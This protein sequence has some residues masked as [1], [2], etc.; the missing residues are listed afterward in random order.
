MLAHQ[1]VI[2]VVVL[3]GVVRGGPLPIVN[4]ANYTWYCDG[5]CDSLTAPNIPPKFGLVLMG[6]GTDV[7]AA[8][9]WMTEKCGGGDF[10]VLRTSGDG[11]YNRYI[12]QLSEQTSNP[13]NSVST[14]VLK[15]RAA[16]FDSFVIDMTKNASGLWFA[17][18]DQWTYYSFWKGSPLHDAFMKSNYETRPIGG[19]SAGN[20][21]QPEFVYTAE[22]DSAYSTETL[23]NPYNEFVQI[24]TGLI[25][26]QHLQNMIT[27][28]H[29]AERDR[30]GRLVGF[31]SRL[32]AD[33]WA[34]MPPST[35]PTFG[36]CVDPAY[37]A[38]GIGVDER[39]ALLI[40]EDYSMSITS[41]DVDGSAYLLC[42]DHLPTTCSPGNDLVVSDISVVRLSGNVTD[43]FQ[44]NNW[45]VIGDRASA[46]YSLSASNGKLDS[47][48]QGGKIY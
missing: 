21:I 33:S 23:R 25:G 9:V 10:L 35:G 17:G 38:R 45:S 15:S 4:N 32:S 27:D 36:N 3:L 22:F 24:G 41:W 48:Q 12:L 11:A 39:T 47:T 5:N 29:F 28:T 2:V 40:E 31:V 18:G 8:Y 14:L 13:L 1:I 26:D 19:T 7:D 43:C 46:I 30:M 20:A 37:G 6:G 44:L 34:P 42:L 16:S